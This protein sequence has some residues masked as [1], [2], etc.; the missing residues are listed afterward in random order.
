MLIYEEGDSPPLI[1]M[2]FAVPNGKDGIVE[3]KRNPGSVRRKEVGH[4]PHIWGQSLYIVARLLSEKLLSPGELD[5]L[6]RRLSTQ[7]R[8]EVVVQVAVLA[9]D[10]IAKQKLAAIGYQVQMASEIKSVSV[11]PVS[12]LMEIYSLLGTS[13]KLGLSGRPK[14]RIG[15]LATSKLYE[16]LN[17]QLTVFFPEFTNTDDFW[18]VADINMLIERIKTE[19]NYLQS[20]WNLAG[21]P[22]I[23]IP[24]SSEILGTGDEVHQ[25]IQTMMKRFESGYSHGVRVNLG[26]L[27]SFLTSS[28][29]CKLYFIEELAHLSEK[30]ESE[31]EEVKSHLAKLEARPITKPTDFVQELIMNRSIDLTDM[32]LVSVTPGRRRRSESGRVHSPIG[33]CRSADRSELL[34]ATT[35]QEQVRI[36]I[37]IYYA[38]DEDYHLDM[39]D[40]GPVKITTLLE[41]VF[42]HAAAEGQW[43]IVRQLAGLL[44]KPLP[45]LD[46]AV[47]DI[48]VRQKSITVGLPPDAR[49]RTINTP[50]QSGEIEHVILEACGDGDVA[51]LQQ[52]V[53]LY[54]AWL[55]RAQPHLFDDLLRLRVG[56]IIQI[57][58]SE[59]SRL[60]SITGPEASAC[61]L[62]LPPSEL[63]TLLSSLLSGQ[64]IA[65]VP[66]GKSI[67]SRSNSRNRRASLG[68]NIHNHI[69]GASKLSAN[70][71][72]D[73]VKNTLLLTMGGLNE[74]FP[75]E[76]PGERVGTWLRRRQLDGALNRVPPDFYKRVWLVLDRCHGLQIGGRLI[77]GTVTREMTSSELKFALLV[78]TTLNSHRCSY[79]LYLYSF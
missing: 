3:E 78:E 60:F 74:E 56:L 59:L 51:I 50:L 48:L 43:L 32:T 24:L 29:V 33:R 16:L 5:P 52:E 55:I 68:E 79:F 10:P 4:L 34:S 71:R 26:P 69:E 30:F 40:I 15:V 38:T 18:I 31:K 63:K 62:S 11:R 64:E 77:Q 2:A 22:T 6:N 41:N 28:Y 13:R 39:G 37:D 75:Y 53:I 1:P 54:L 65:V 73:S 20:H 76:P 7:K 72:H 70:L 14:K 42:E 25:A 45:G 21:R 27:E 17:C 35:L 58:A 66:D 61:L 36:L 12:H 9:T 8:P 57:L 67:R 23:V 49:E 44:E 19:L 47:T 46:Q